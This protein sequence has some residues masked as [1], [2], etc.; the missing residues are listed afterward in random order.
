M[1]RCW[2]LVFP[3]YQL[4]ITHYQLP[5][6]NYPL[7]NY[8]PRRHR[9]FPCLP[10]F[11]LPRLPSKA[12]GYDAATFISAFTLAYAQSNHGSKASISVVSTV[13][14][15]QILIPGGAAR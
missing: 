12:L 15:P 1:L 11:A 7:P 9:E 2:A 14:P 10:L 8:Q 3:H 6:T 4:P 13:A 5:I